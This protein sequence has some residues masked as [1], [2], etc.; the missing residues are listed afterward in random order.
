M[1]PRMLTCSLILSVF[2]LLRGSMPIPAAQATE[3][4]MNRP[5]WEYKVIKL[6]EHQ[7][8]SENQLATSLNSSGQ[9]G[10]ELISYERLS[11]AYPRDAEGTLLLRPAATGQGRDHSPQTADSFQGTITMK[12][13]QMQLGACRFLFKR[14]VAAATLR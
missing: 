5:K 12:M 8:S 13:A 11:L 1:S 3:Y 2:A 6:D 4:Q 9:E 14:Q 7:C 10:W